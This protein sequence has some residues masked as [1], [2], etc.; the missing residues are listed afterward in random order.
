MHDQVEALWVPWPN[1][2][3]H[4]SMVHGAGCVKVQVMRKV[5]QLKQV[6][7]CSWHWTECQC[8]AMLAHHDTLD[9]DVTGGFGSHPGPDG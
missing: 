5:K 1:D 8:H 3:C 2:Q 4:L 6:L 7:G 9:L